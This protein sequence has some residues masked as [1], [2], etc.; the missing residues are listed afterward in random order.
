MFPAENLLETLFEQQML[1]Q[2][3]PKQKKP[4]AGAEPEIMNYFYVFEAD[5]GAGS[6][7]ESGSVPV[8]RTQPDVHGE[9][10]TAEK[11]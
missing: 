6:S 11:S 10:G 5:A 9:E 1:C 3:P 7:E 4:N 2:K 8:G